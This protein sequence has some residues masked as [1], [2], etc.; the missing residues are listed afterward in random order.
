VGLVSKIEIEGK[1]ALSEA[2]EVKNWG[3]DGL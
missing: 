1:D 2:S 3:K